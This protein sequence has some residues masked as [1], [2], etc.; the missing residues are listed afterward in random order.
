MLIQF[1]VK[2]TLRKY[3]ELDSD[4]LIN[5]KLQ[6]DRNKQ[7]DYSELPSLRLSYMIED[8]ESF[9]DFEKPTDNFA[10]LFTQRVKN[11]V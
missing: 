5:G 9:R 8:F 7:E 6:R 1:R 3:K 10:Q 11:S 4:S 2:N